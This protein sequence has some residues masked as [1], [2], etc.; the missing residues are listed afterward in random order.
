MQQTNPEFE[1]GLLILLSEGVLKLI[2]KPLSDVWSDLGNQD[3]S[4]SFQQPLNYVNKCLLACLHTFVFRH[5][6]FF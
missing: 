2:K 3:G 6:H 4:R 1:L 5:D